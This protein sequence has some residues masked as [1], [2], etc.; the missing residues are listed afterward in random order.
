MSQ[1]K[2]IGPIV[3]LSI[4]AAFAGTGC[5]AE[6]ADEDD[7]MSDPEIAMAADQDDPV[8]EEQKENVGEAEQAW[9]GGFGGCGLGFGGCGIGLG[10]CGFGLGGF[11]G[12]GLG[13][14]GCGLGFGGCGLGL[15]LGGCGGFG[16]CW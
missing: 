16:G 3:A 13:F 7:V 4:T 12:C 15:G 2:N 10:G 1:W 8:V 6:S 14:G 9:W 11:G 5:L